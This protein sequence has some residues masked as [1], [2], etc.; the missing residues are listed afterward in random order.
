MRPCDMVS[1]ARESGASLVSSL[2]GGG[3]G[4][5]DLD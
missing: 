2:S 1:S 3:G 4:I 5:G